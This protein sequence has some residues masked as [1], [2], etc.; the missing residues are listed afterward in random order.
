MYCNNNYLLYNK[1]K[2]YLLSTDYLL[3]LLYVK[4]VCIDKHFKY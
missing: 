4:C 1:K 3:F 2:Y